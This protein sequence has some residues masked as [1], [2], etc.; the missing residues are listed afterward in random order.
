MI[1]KDVLVK[2][3]I[4][5][6]MTATT[7]KLQRYGFVVKRDATKDQIKL[8]VKEL[9]GVEVISVNTMIYAGKRKFRG[10]RKG[11]V[12]GRTNAF[13]KAIVCLK[14]GEVIDFYSNI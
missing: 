10:T 11:Y 14:E 6:K 3:L 2:P 4:T 13:K 7:E 9:Y 12:Q 1:K 5:E 8:A